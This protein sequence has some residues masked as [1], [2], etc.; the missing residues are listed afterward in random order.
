MAA[1]SDADTLCVLQKMKNHKLLLADAVHAVL[2]C[3]LELLSG[4]R[5]L[6]ALASQSGLQHA[7]AVRNASSGS[8]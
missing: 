6:G 4:W 1:W 7:G 8:C 3:R 2:D 5:P